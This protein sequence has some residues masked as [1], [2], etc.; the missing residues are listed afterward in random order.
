MRNHNVIVSSTF[1][2]VDQKSE[3]SREGAI[4]YNDDLFFLIRFEMHLYLN[5]E[6]HV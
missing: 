6:L 5:K 4:V 3:Q 1:Y 2:H